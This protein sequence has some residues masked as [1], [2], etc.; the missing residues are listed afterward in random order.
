MNLIKKP[1]KKP[2]K[3]NI[4]FRVETSILVIDI[5]YSEILSYTDAIIVY[6]FLS[7][8]CFHFVFVTDLNDKHFYRYMTLHAIPNK[9][10]DHEQQFLI[11]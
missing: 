2:Y 6:V 4:C 10:M 8:A 11:Q 9:K 1:G 7:F 5:I 3:M